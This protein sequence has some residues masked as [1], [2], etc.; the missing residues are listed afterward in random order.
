MREAQQ[1]AK[2]P[3]GYDRLCLGRSREERAQLPGFSPNPVVRMRIPDDPPTHFTD[4]IRGEVNAPHPDDQVILKADGFPTYHLAVVVDDHEMAITHVVRG[5]E[6]ISSTPKHILLYQWLD[7]PVPQFAHMPLLRNDDRSKISKRKN[8]AARL[9]W[10]RE[11]G[12]LPEALVN[13]LGLMGYSMPD[14]RE[15][16]TFAEMS[17]EFDWSRVN[18]VGPVFNLDKLNWLNGHYIRDLSVDELTQR[19]LGYLTTVGSLAAEPTDAQREMV[20]AATPLVQERMQTL[21]EAP[22]LL[23]FLLVADEDLVVTDDGRKALTA[24][25]GATLDAAGK[26][27]ES[28]RDWRTADIEGALRAALVDGM[29]L[30]PRLAFTPVRIAVTGRRVSP[31]LFE[32]MELLGRESTLSRIGALRSELDA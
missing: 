29:G 22:D 15:I 6:W 31:P 4:L 11:Q 28:V 8:P 14:E 25:A 30:K 24:D 19:I 20:R 26:A 18:V 10:F 7:L 2:Q 3:P 21:A 13:F 5:E 12:Y 17:A 27:L 16:F 1:K 32:S 23:G 9:T